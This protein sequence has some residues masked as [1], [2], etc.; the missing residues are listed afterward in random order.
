MKKILFFILIAVFI[1]GCNKLSGGTHVSEMVKGNV[2]LNNKDYEMIISD[3]TWKTDNVEL[4]KLSPPVNEDIV[5]E[6]KTL[7]VEKTD[8]MKIEFEHEQNPS[9]IKVYQKDEKGKIVK[10]DLKENEIPLP[11]E[12]GYY[13]YN[14]KTKWEE[15]ELSYVFDV[16][17][18]N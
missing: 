7:E 17:L 8:T 13:L 18:S 1:S 5:R 3:F 16:N 6:F 12:T 11:S 15:G 10:V 14:V 4:N 2:I 9:S